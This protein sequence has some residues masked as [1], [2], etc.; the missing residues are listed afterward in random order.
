[1]ILEFS[2]WLWYFYIELTQIT[3]AMLLLLLALLAAS[4][5]RTSPKQHLSQ[6]TVPPE[7]SCPNCGEDCVDRLVITE[8]GN[9][10]DQVLCVSCNEVYP[11]T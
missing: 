5:Y 11:T 9:K 2:V 8:L 6:T 7:L 10:A 3:A 4:W 1:M